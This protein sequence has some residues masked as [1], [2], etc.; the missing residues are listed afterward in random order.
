MPCDQPVQFSGDPHTTDRCINNAG[1]ALTR[2][3]VD[4]V[5]DPD[6]SSIAQLIMQEV[7]AP[8]HVDLGRHGHRLAHDGRSSLSTDKDSAQMQTN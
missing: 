2:I 3:I 5:Q 1:Q 6:A 7:H 4:H 8:S